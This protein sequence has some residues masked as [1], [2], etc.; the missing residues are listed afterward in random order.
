MKMKGLGLKALGKGAKGYAG[1]RLLQRAAL[2][3]RRGGRTPM[4]LAGAALGATVVYFLDP[5]EGARRRHEARDRAMARLRRGEH[6][7]A[8]K[9]RYAAGQAAGAA[10]ERR[11]EQPKS[12]LTDQ[13][14]AHKVETIIFRDPQVPK[15]EMNV[16]AAGSVVWLRGEA[17]SQEMIADLEQKALAIPEVERVE[18]L[19]HMPGEPG[20]TRADAPP[21]QRADTSHSD[22]PQSTPSS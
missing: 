5:R 11:G 6:R 22:A 3:P 2:S 13:D 16:D 19:L 17:P 7:A 1:L 10:H 12:G 4:L 9:A 14:L 8:S 20:P 18:N 21:D 15:G